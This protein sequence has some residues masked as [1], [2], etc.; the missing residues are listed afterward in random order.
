M[1]F[2]PEEV[3]TASSHP[4]GDFSAQGLSQRNVDVP[5]GCLRIYLE[6]I[7]VAHAYHDGFSA[8][9]AARVYADLLIRKEPAH[10]Q[11]LESSL[12]VPFLLTLYAYQ[13]W[14]WHIGE[15]RP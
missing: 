10:G 6:D 3:H 9:K 12:T 14:G 5:N 15:R 1:F 11:R 13:I 7:L 2:R 4:P 8:V